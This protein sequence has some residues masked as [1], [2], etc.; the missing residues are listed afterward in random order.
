MSQGIVLLLIIAVI[1][2]YAVTRA[3]RRMGLHV[4][5]KTWA[6]IIAGF[7]ILVLSMWA[8]ASRG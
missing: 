7:A 2:A 3:R 1:V 8:A 5:G 4:T 6:T